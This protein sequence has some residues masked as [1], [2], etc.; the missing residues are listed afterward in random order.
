[1]ERADVAAGGAP[2][3]PWWQRSIKAV[4]LTLLVELATPTAVDLVRNQVKDPPGVAIDDLGG[5]EVDP[6]VAI[7]KACGETVVAVKHLERPDSRVGPEDRYQ[8]WEVVP[9]PGH[10]DR[11]FLD[12]KTGGAICP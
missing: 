7:L 3:E 6:K 12:T 9:R 5:R 8:R 11:A 1:V 4:G 10:V 2:R